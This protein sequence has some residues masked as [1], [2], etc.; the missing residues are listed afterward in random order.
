M[1]D[2]NSLI[3]FG[4][5]LSNIIIGMYC[6]TRRGAFEALCVQLCAL[7]C[8]IATC[9][10]HLK[11]FAE[12]HKSEFGSLVKSEISSISAHDK[13]SAVRVWEIIPSANGCFLSSCKQMKL[14]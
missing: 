14:R 8:R 12:E 13:V 4:T 6:S 11:S 2:L 1:F 9:E 3:L 10:Q 7:C 5:K